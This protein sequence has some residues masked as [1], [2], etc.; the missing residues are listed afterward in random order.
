MKEKKCRPITVLLD[1]KIYWVNIVKQHNIFLILDYKNVRL[2]LK[3]NRINY[4]SI[5]SK[6]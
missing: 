6:P 1:I 3:H 2:I 4:C 5:E